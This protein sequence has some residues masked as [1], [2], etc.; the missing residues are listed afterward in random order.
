MDEHSDPEIYDGASGN[1]PPEDEQSLESDNSDAEVDI[2]EPNF[3]EEDF[4]ESRSPTPSSDEPVIEK[5]AIEEMTPTLD[6]GIDIVN[7]STGFEEIQS[8]TDDTDSEQNAC[9]REAME[10][11]PHE[12][13]SSAHSD[14]ASNISLMDKYQWPRLYELPS[15]LQKA[16]PRNE[17]R[18]VHLKLGSFYLHHPYICRLRV[19]ENMGFLYL[20]RLNLTESG[21]IKN[22]N[23]YRSRVL[24]II[25]DAFLDLSTTEIILVWPRNQIDSADAT[26]DETM[27]WRIKVV[28]FPSTFRDDPLLV[29]TGLHGP[30]LLNF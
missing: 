21:I 14:N 20:D 18:T 29:C 30:T 2:E 1:D 26:M 22:T 17:H 12:L 3:D 6:R 28:L 5:L 19:S 27:D 11:S 9:I 16:V 13:S 4:D 24:C 7:N 10:S 8:S 25:P 15:E 23:D